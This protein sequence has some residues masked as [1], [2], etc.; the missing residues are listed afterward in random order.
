MDT[1]ENPVAE[2]RL[3]GAL[4]PVIGSVYF[5]PEAHQNYVELGFDPSPGEVNGVAMP[6]GT[7]YS[8]SRGSLLGNARGS[9]VAAAFGVFEPKGLA[10]GVDRGWTITDAATI[11]DARERG[12][13]D[14]LER[15][16]GTD[17]VGRDRVQALLQQATDGLVIGPRH[18]AAGAAVAP[19][20][21]H[22]LGTIFRLGDLL[23]EFR[24]DSHNAAWAQAGLDATQ[25]GLLTELFWGLPLRTYTR[26]RGWSDA[27][28]DAAEEDLRSRGLIDADGAFTTDG[29][30]F[31]EEIEV[32][33]D[34]QMSHV[35]AN[36]DGDADELIE[37]LSGWGR[38]VRAA[39]GYLSSGPHD[40][41]AAG[42]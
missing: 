38:Q 16:L 28:F 41:A 39:N 14:Q 15:I 11:C 7:A 20:L 1:A 35:M 9:V 23:R 10:A 12:A 25:I 40:L 31:R 36:L 27:Q 30:Q 32:A 8:T 18:L 42:S 3:G 29:R 5:S 6:E 26:T 4:E 13:V 19:V 22:P 33:T 17:P 34:R 37:I 21:D 2:R 24:G